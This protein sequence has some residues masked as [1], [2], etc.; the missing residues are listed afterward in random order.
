MASHFRKI[1]VRSLLL[2]VFLSGKTVL[3]AEPVLVYGVLDVGLIGGFG[4]RIANNPANPDLRHDWGLGNGNGFRHNYTSRIGFT[5]KESLGGGNS[6]EVRLEGTAVPS[7]PFEFDRQAYIALNGDFGSLRAGRTRDLI[8]GIASRVDPF[9]NDGLV[10]DKILIAQAAGVGVFRIPDSL[11]YVSPTANGLI[12]SVQFG[13]NTAS[14]GSHGLKLLLTY[15]QG[16]W[17]AHVGVDFP[18]RSP[19]TSGS[20]AGKFSL[21]SGARNIIAGAFYDFGRFKLAGEVLHSSRDETAANVLP[22]TVNGSGFGWISSLRIPTPG[23]EAKV[24]L[25]K[26]DM[27]FNKNLVQQPIREIGFGYDHFLSKKTFLF[28]QVGMERVSNG[29]HWHA[30]MNTRF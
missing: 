25:V 27:V 8:N 6:I 30:G 19:I 20:E 22:A 16:P 18:R 5:R 14:A 28:I 29:G 11:T 4:T 24:V 2:F 15:D 17:G 9:N 23:G 7:M 13:I 26:S 3:A 1:L 12:G 10:E 21:G